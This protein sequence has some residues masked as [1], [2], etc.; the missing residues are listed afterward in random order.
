MQTCEP[1]VL[2]PL[3]EL[4]EDGCGAIASRPIHMGQ[5]ITWDKREVPCS[6]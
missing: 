6:L 1:A 5:H 4:F 2:P 3:H